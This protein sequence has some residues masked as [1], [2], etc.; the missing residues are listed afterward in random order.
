MVL[1][2]SV[3]WVIIL[4]L[5]FI[6]I[7]TMHPHVSVVMFSSDPIPLNGSLVGTKRTESYLVTVVRL[8]LC[9]SFTA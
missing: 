3:I 1:I 6:W 5:T 9:S 2:D 8:L 4:R 7:V